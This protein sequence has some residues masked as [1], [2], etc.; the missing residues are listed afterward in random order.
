[1]A[2]ILKGLCE[3]CGHTIVLQTSKKV[4]GPRG[5]SRWES[6]L[7]AVWGQMA[8]GQGNSQLGESL[9]VIGVPV[10]TK[11]SFIA[12]ERAIGERWQVEMQEQMAKAGQEEKRL[13][14]ERGSYHEGVP[15]ITVIV[16]GGWSKHS[17]KHTYNAKSGVAI[18]IGKATGKLL[19]I[20]VRNKHCHACAR[21]IP[22][23]DH[24]CYKNWSASSSEMETDI[25]LE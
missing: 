20:R 25:I 9:S 6:N 13:A 1:M 10:M 3:I 21:G 14:E 5:T 17:H 15:A 22:Q 4:K 18:I 19:H 7:A 2:S 11:A 8:T 24:A 12:T 23:K 16:D